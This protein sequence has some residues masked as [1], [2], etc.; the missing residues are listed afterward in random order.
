[1]WMTKTDWFELKFVYLLSSKHETA[2]L[3]ADTIF[4]GEGEDLQ[5]TERE[6]RSASLSTN[7]KNSLSLTL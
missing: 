4:I 2:P 1:M 3:S 6:T 5:A 7:V